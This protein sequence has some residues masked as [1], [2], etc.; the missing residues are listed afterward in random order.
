MH[1][2]IAMR[3]GRLTSAIV[4]AALAGVAAGQV[5]TSELPT[6]QDPVAPAQS[7][8]RDATDASASTTEVPLVT[9]TSEPAPPAPDKI[10][11]S[12]DN[13]MLAISPLADERISTGPALWVDADYLLWQIRRGPLPTPLVTTG[14]PTDPLPGAL[15]RP[16]SLALFGGSP[17]DYGTFSGGRLNIGGWLD[18][19]RTIGAEVG[20]FRL[21]QRAIRGAVASDRAG[22]PPIYLPVI[23]QDPSSP[24]FGK[25]SIY[26][27]ADPLFPDPTGPTF[28]H[29]AV[30]SNTRLWGAELNGLVNLARTCSWSCDGIVGF[31][32][33]DLREDLR[34]SGFSN[35]LFDDLQQTFNDRFRT[36]NQ[37]YG[38]QLG[39]RC[40]YRC[41][42]FILEATGKVALG[43]TH[44]VVD[45]QG[46]STWGGTGFFPAPGVYP[47]GV[48]TQT[49]NIG[50]NNADYLTVVPQVGLKLGL[51]I[52]PCLTA[53]VGY[54]FLYW[55]SVVRP[56]NQIDPNLNPTQFPGAG[57]NG[58][59]LP[60][61]LFNRSDFFAHGVSF[62][63]T[64]AY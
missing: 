20:G 38:G 28:G 39:A 61:P 7:S 42:K 34:I 1:R 19:V 24:T 23:N 56:G 59:L 6:N 64:F 27:V 50:R 15:G 40:G 52:T 41:D 26:T 46:N 53:N 63:L 5:P 13:F 37:F 12:P 16:D 31:R 48:Y 57:F 17:L 25:E 18:C 9:V 29:V 33:L 10:F 14:N 32:Y 22:D 4:V 55:S 35:D 8:T 43:S 47:G 21:E 44:E 45:I 60:A 62:G 49:S 3:H 51:N 54:D 36:R 30:S 2:R 58:A 11:P